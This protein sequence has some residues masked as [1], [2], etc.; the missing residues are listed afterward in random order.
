[1]QVS[2]KEFGGY[3]AVLNAE[4]QSVINLV[5]KNSSYRSAEHDLEAMCAMFPDSQIV[6]CMKPGKTKCMYACVYG[7]GMYFYSLL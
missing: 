4:I 7:L 1:M 2:I 3:Y 5:K 6:Q